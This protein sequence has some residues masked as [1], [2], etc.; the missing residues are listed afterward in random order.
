MTINYEK[1]KEEEEEEKEK[2]EEEKKKREGMGLSIK[3]VD[4]QNEAKL[5]NHKNDKLLEE[6]EEEEGGREGGR[7]GKSVR[8]DEIGKGREK[9]VDG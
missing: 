2:K 4:Q 3:K 5:T 7:R 1:K 6:E 8:T 9:G